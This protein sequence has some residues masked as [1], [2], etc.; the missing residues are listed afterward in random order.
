MESTLSLHKQICW[1]IHNAESV[2]PQSICQMQNIHVWPRWSD[3]FTVQPA[4]LWQVQIDGIR[5][6]HVFCSLHIWFALT[7]V[8]GNTVSALNKYLKLCQHNIFCFQGWRNNIVKKK[9]KIN[10]HTQ[11]LMSQVCFS[12]SSISPRSLFLAIADDV[13][14]VHF[15]VPAQKVFLV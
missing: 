6:C 13:A 7:L 8:L 4:V 3:W 12:F 9:N 5:A 15:E 1:A 10:T 11:I 2:C 14:L